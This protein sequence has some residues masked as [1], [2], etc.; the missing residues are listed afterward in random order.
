MDVQ[1]L[2]KAKSE[3]EEI[4]CPDCKSRE[5]ETTNIYTSGH[6][7]A[8]CGYT[9]ADALR[10]NLTEKLEEITELRYNLDILASRLGYAKS[11]TD[12]D[13]L[14]PM[15]FA[16]QIIEENKKLKEK[17]QSCIELLLKT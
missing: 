14:S 9:W 3:K 16:D 10:K 15:D 13:S 4:R 7:C 12:Q 2:E 5:V 1:K 8:S 17:I 11:A 6:I